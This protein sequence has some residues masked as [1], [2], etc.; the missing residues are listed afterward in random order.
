MHPGVL[1]QKRPRTRV[2]L[3]LVPAVCLCLSPPAVGQTP[4]S[5]N[6][7]SPLAEDRA[8]VDVFSGADRQ[9]VRGRLL[10]VTPSTLVLEGRT[11]RTEV[12]AAEVREVWSPGGP[13]YRKPVIVG[14]AVGLSFGLLAKAGEGDCRDPTSLCATDGPVTG[15]DIAIVTAIGASSGLGWAWWKRHPRHLLY[16]SSEAMAEMGPPPGASSPVPVGVRPDWQELAG[17][18]GGTVEVASRGSGTTLKG[19]LLGVTPRTI[20]LLV[21]GEPYVI[22]QP[23]VLKVWSEPRAPWWSVVAGSLYYGLPWG[24]VVAAASC[25]SGTQSD[26]WSACDSQALG[27]TIGA[28]AALF[29][30]AVYKQR[31]DA[32]AYDRSRPVPASSSGLVLQPLLSPRAV[33]VRGAFTY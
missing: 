21:A 18:Q 14:T 16:L 33:G 30:V 11:G 28:Y 3:W 17:L 12:P 15:T 7:L 6:L 19:T 5:L 32:L 20:H 29:T 1:W 31:H 13:R 4:S 24:A 22:P 26:E 27:I 9:F 10:E 25:G 8:K 23:E 2:L